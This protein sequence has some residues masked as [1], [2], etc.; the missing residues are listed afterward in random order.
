MSDTIQNDYQLNEYAESC[1]RDILAEIAE[2]G[3]DSSEM[4]HEYADGSEH[5]IY[6]YLAHAICQ[7]CNTDEGEAFLEAVGNPDPVTYDRLAATIAYG[8][9]RARIESA[10]AELQDES[11]N[12]A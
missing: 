7:N 6:Y 11:E 3:G 2:H 8:E 5:V 9:L 1:A 12:A 4:A 10:I